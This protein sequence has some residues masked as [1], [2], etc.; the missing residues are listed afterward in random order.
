[1]RKAGAGS[2]RATRFQRG[3]KGFGARMVTGMG[4]GML[5]GMMGPEAQGAMNLG[6]M[7][8]M[9]NPLL[10]MGIGLGGAALKS[11]TAKGGMASGAGAGA[12]MGAMIGPGGALAG[13]VIGGLVGGVMGSIGRGRAQVAEVKASAKETA[14]EIWAGMIAGIDDL[15]ASGGVMTGAAV[16]HAMGVGRIGGII[17]GGTAASQAAGVGTKIDK[18][19]AAGMAGHAMR[20][21][22]VRDIYDNQSLLGVEMSQEELNKNLRRPFEFLEEILPELT[23]HH[24]VANV[25][26]DKYTARMTHMTS[27]FDVSEEKLLE[28]AD[29]VGVNLYDAAADTTEMMKQLSGALMQTRDMIDNVYQEILSTSY[30]MLQKEITQVEGELGVDESA[31]AFR[32]AYDRGEIDPSTSEGRM[33]VMSFIQEQL[34]FTTDF[35][36]GDSMAATEAIHD[37]FMGGTAFTQSG[38][39]LQ[40]LGHIFQ[41]PT[42]QAALG[43]MW[44]PA[45][46]NK[47]MQQQVTSNLMGFGLTG[48]VGNLTNLSGDQML[49][50]DKLFSD[51]RGAEKGGALL[52]EDGGLTSMGKQGMLSILS[53]IGI[54]VSNIQAYTEAAGTEGLTGGDMASFATQFG[55]SVG[56]FEVAVQDFV[57]KINP[58]AQDTKHPIGDTSSTLA[59][60]LAAHGR[61]SG[62]LPGKRTIT[63]G[64]RNY[65]LGSINSDHVTGKALDIVGS[66][67]GAYQTGIKNAGGFA[68]FHG[69]GDSRHL[70]TVPAA[71]DT[72]TSR[73]GLGGGSNTNNYTINVAGGPNAN[74]QEV[75]SLVMNEIQNLNRSNRERS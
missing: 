4:M 24:G 49:R 45:Q 12:A 43:N 16:R 27:M 20:Q 15:R 71:G 13:A 44:D 40:G 11:Q 65:A 51:L 48:T 37:A 70:H 64:Y 2:L 5:S 6:S 10:G 21:A 57:H 17:T 29:T 58:S 25:V 38:G 41:D 69:M 59:G 32:E 62:G 18:L 14:D 28:M 9:V 22:A 39:H 60:T 23:K 35:M 56:D 7:V 66:N 19:D 3:M 26:L 75:A 74:A 63:S 47:I 34:G 1:M 68:E 61:I 54:P 55:T 42:I 46:K 53:S 72:S 8:S 50:M 52:T 67:L 31:R 30:N 36:G 33:R 73:G